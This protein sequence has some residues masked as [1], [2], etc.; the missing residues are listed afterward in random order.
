MNASGWID[1]LKLSKGWTSDYRVAKEL[2]FNANTI[3]L[4]RSRGG[5]MDESI[6][7]KVAIALGERPEAVLLDQLAERT[8]D[9]A[10]RA[11]LL[12]ASRAICILCKVA[13]G[14]EFVTPCNDTCRYSAMALVACH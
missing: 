5:L 6:A 2:S 3:S 4:Y 7:I 9:P 14:E 12:A 13:C 8:K 10:A 1:K 11:A